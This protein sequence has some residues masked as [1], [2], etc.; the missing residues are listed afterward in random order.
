[1][2]SIEVTD[3][4]CGMAPETVARIFEP[5]F[6]TK[7]AG[8]GLGL[9]AVQGIVRGH[10]GL[11]KVASEVGMGTR[12]QILFPSLPTAPPHPLPPI[13]P[14]QVGTAR[15]PGR[16]SILVVEDESAA[17]S[18]TVRVLRDAGFDVLE[19]GD[20][21]EGVTAFRLARGAIRAV[22]MDLTLPG[23]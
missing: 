16:G 7:F 3:T 22:L 18:F 5:F 17:R 12:V 6:T 21:E 23:L 1:Y 13:R 19:A 11:I 20:G 4:G 9:A 8:R 14:S 15:V 10:R 2:V